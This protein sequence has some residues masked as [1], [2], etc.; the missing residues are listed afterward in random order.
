MNG[1]EEGNK[2]E[3]GGEERRMEQKIDWE[4]RERKRRREVWEGRENRSE[5]ESII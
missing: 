2:G 4:G 5:E 3:E 1:K